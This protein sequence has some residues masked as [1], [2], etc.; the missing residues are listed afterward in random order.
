MHDSCQ[1]YS[2]VDIKVTFH[3]VIMLTEHSDLR[4]GIHLKV[5]Y[6][7]FFELRVSV[8]C[9]LMNKIPTRCSKSSL[10][11]LFFSLHVSGATFTHHQ[12]PQLYKRSLYKSFVWLGEVCARSRSAVQTPSPIIR[13]L[14]YTSGYGVN[15]INRLCS[16]AKCVPDPDQLYGRCESEMSP[17]N[18]SEPDEEK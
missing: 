11:S 1:W 10:F 15:C 17:V 8:H 5:G 12:E 9:G 18:V 13:S 3:L 2:W 14:N 6:F 4:G 16:W 7:F